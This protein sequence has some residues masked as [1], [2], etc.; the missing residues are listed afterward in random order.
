MSNT[1]LRLYSEF[2]SDPKVQMMSEIMQRRFI[3]LLCFRCNGL[4]TLQDEEV[5]F[6]LRISNEDWQETRRLFIARGFLDE[7]NNLVNWDKRQYRSDSSAERVRKHRNN[8]K[9]KDV[10]KCNVT[11]TPQNRYRTDTDI[12]RER[13]RAK[14]KIKLEDL[15]LDHISDWLAKKRG[16]G[17]YLQHD[18]HFILEYFKSYCTSKNK[19]YSDYPAALRNAFEWE[20]CKQKLNGGQHGRTEPKSQIQ[21]AIEATE[22]ARLAREHRSASETG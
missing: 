20:S 22:R 7:M 15:S 10:T 5:T 9:Q 3:M 2:A 13:A 1:W 14:N 8:M 4:V 18:E 21:R 6:L 11:V 17:K 16:E 12:E 19:T